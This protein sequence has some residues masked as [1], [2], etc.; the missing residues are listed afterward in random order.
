MDL[1]LDNLQKLICHKTQQTK[2]NQTKMIKISVK[3]DKPN[4]YNRFSGNI[5]EEVFIYIYN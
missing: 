2:P 4:P 1:A 3:V 5:S